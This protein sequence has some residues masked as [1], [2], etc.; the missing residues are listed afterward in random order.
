MTA[1]AE[2]REEPG[3][4]NNSKTEG[5]DAEATV[6]DA[7]ADDG[8]GAEKQGKDNDNKDND[9]QRYIPP[10]KKPDA[11]LTFPEKVRLRSLYAQEGSQSLACLCP[12][13]VCSPPPPCFLDVVL[14]QR[15]TRR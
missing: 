7:A 6:V 11:A 10:Y 15:R 14:Q 9:T 8:K 4:T 12:L 1:G 13:R 2:G 5:T 3:A